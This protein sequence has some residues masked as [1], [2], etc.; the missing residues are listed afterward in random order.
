MPPSLP[1]IGQ[2]GP[3]FP[4]FG[5]G[6][7]S[8]LMDL[9]ASLTSPLF[10]HIQRGGGPDIPRSAAALLSGNGTGPPGFV[11]P[12]QLVAASAVP[13]NASGQAAQSA[14]N[15]PLANFAIPAPPVAAH[16]PGPAFPP[17]APTEGRPA[18]AGG[19][20]AGRPFSGNG[21]HPVH[22]GHHPAHGAQHPGHGAQHPASAT[23]GTGLA[24]ATHGPLGHVV[25]TV[26]STA[27]HTVAIAATVA[28]ALLGRSSSPASQLPAQAQAQASGEAQA[29]QA[30]R[31]PV[32]GS[33]HSAGQPTQAGTLHSI[34]QPIQASIP[35]APPS[36]RPAAFGQPAAGLPVYPGGAAVAAGPAATAS[37]ALA[38]G[39][40]GTAQPMAATPGAPLSPSAAAATNTPLSSATS[41]PQPPVAARAEGM[42]I[43]DRAALQSPAAMPATA[44]T[45][46]SPAAMP[47]NPAA[48]Q[49]T[50]PAPATAAAPA[51]S[52]PGNPQATN[53][54]MNPAAQ[55]VVPATQGAEA[56]GNTMLTGTG[57]DRSH[58]RSDGPLPQGH[59]VERAQRGRMRTLG[60]TI[61]AALGQ[62][63][64]EETRIREQ[65]DATFRWLYW[66]LTI[67]AWLCVVLLVAAVVPTFST[68]G[69]APAP[70]QTA[71]RTF[72]GVIGLGICTG[73]AAWLMTRRRK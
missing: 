30:G 24:A 45:P 29:Q 69:M 11:P 31:A 25:S 65:A 23:T 2:L 54:S 64:D 37:L 68:S 8:P 66:A 28:Q 13:F 9:R 40:A 70:W 53:A 16:P 73:F 67:T 1:G 18:H 33:P 56:R 10:L 49:T 17:G 6:N 43:A 34:G 36:G 15:P 72:A 55:Q 14:P 7:G 38:A 44:A 19:P 42:A 5:R 35:N 41:L 4:G 58:V 48:P 71:P 61:L 62:A 47:A 22:G 20:H 51:L 46:Q 26:A 57:A 3:P 63:R 50:A 60:A 27:G 32:A 39:P 12:G 21:H 59:T 52:A